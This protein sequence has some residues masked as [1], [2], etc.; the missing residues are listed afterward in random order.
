MSD[1][2]KTCGTCGWWARVHYLGEKTLKMGRCENESSPLCDRLTA[3]NNNCGQWK[4]VSKE[5]K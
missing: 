2:E 5:L 4:E 1:A 3:A